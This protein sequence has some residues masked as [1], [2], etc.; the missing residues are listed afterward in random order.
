[1]INERDHVILGCESLA[2]GIEHVE[3]LTGATPVAGGRHDAMGTHNALVKLGQRL[4]LE[5]LAI[6]PDAKA[7]ARK[8]WFDLDTPSMQ[9]ALA[10]KP[11]VIGW[12]ARSDDI[13]DALMRSAIPPGATHTMTRAGLT[14]R[15]TIPEDGVRPAG[16]VLP[17]LIQWSTDEHPADRLP[18][19]GC[20]LSQIAAAHP[21]PDS[22]RAAL[23]ALRLSEAMQ[24]T[25]AEAPR[26]AVMLR[27]PRG[28][29]SI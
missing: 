6:D 22:I 20:S 13:D 26:I 17:A 16:G 1:M 29:V 18:E 9:A 28:L 3:R 10:D 24:V 21:E 25:Y 14:W 27:T 5:I 4:Y 2:Q 15:I 11:Q 12:A 7:P 23:K 19:A 8:R